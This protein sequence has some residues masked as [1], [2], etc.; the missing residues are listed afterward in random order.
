M[1]NYIKGIKEIVINPPKLEMDKSSYNFKIRYDYEYRKLKST[2]YLE[3]NADYIPIV[4]EKSN[5]DMIYNSYIKHISRMP[6]TLAISQYLLFIKK[7]SQLSKNESLY[8]IIN[9]MY[10]PNTNDILND[11][12]DKYKDNDGFLYITLYKENTFG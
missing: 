7:Y 6:K 5:G 8:V 11:L 4:L 2:E 1:L 9:N 3:K 10:I 12:Y